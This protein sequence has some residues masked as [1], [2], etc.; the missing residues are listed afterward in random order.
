MAGAAVVALTAAACGSALAQ[1]PPQTNPAPQVA[2]PQAPAPQAAVV[3]V[4]QAPAAAPVTAA[5]A[6]FA[7]A[8]ATAPAAPAP[9]FP[10]QPA[11][12]AQKRGFLNEF[13]QWWEQSIADFKTK[14]QDQQTKL[15]TINKQ[16]ADAAKDAAAAT[17][18]AMKN[19]ADAMTHFSHVVEVQQ[20]CP[21]AGN[22]A[23]DC[24]TA[25]VNACKAK[26]YNAGQ[27]IDVRT[28]E[29][30]TD[31]LWVSGQR[32]TAGDCPVETVI[33]RVACQ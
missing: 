14:W 20:K 17:S 26:G 8:P 30:C 33:L 15:D 22:G 25:A 18:Q 23:A 29:T 10:P 27:P 4:Q 2:S 32:P 31:S 28:A 24:E 16:Q 6:P 19:A 13:G 12:P 21:L 7:A 9:G 3:P 11:P 1:T 5:T